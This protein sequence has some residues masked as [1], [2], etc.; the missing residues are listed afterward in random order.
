MSGT[1]R[2]MRALNAAE[3]LQRRAQMARAALLREPEDDAPVPLELGTT[4][5]KQ[6]DDAI[7]SEVATGT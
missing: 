4:Q 2:D 6:F 5:L 1:M 7:T 3:I